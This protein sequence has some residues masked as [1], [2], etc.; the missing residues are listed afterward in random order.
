MLSKK[1]DCEIQLHQAHCGDQKRNTFNI[2]YYMLILMMKDAF[3]D[4]FVLCINSV[5]QK[6]VLF[7]IGLPHFKLS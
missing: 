1:L 7:V 3:C 4:H 5:C 6:S 2:K